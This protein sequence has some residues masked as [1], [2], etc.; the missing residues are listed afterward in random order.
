MA[1]EYSRADVFKRIYQK[2]LV[3]EAAVMELT[4]WAEE[5]DAA[6]APRII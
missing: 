1:S 5:L 2:Q 4:V 3:L 6:Q